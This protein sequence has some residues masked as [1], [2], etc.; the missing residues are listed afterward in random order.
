MWAIA[1]LCAGLVWHWPAALSPLKLTLG[2][3]ALVGIRHRS[4]WLGAFAFGLL[5]VPFG[6]M[7]LDFLT[8]LGNAR[9]TA[10]LNVE[11]VLGDI[12]IALGLILASAG[13]LAPGRGL[14][15][16]QRVRR[17]AQHLGRAVEHPSLPAVRRVPRIEHG[18][19]DL[20]LGG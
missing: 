19:R 13:E 5:C 6:T 3:F 10:A 16:L 15:A 18:L 8:A 11:Y 7:W 2:P 12:P 9:Q 20:D 1:A 14:A 4:W 17:R